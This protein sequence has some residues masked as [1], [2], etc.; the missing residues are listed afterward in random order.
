MNN[1][2][3]MYEDSTCNNCKYLDECNP[4]YQEQENYCEGWE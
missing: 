1:K 4:D 3:C 2:Y